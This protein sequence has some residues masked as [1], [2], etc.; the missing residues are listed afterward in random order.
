MEYSQIQVTMGVDNFTKR[1]VFFLNP[2]CL[3]IFLNDP[4]KKSSCLSSVPRGNSS[5]EET[6]ITSFTVK[7]KLLNIFQT[8]GRRRT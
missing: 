3:D 7:G 6:E 8:D 4:Q 1:P 2:K 5:S